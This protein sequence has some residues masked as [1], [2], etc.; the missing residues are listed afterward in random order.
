MAGAPKIL[1]P[2]VAGFVLLQ[3]FISGMGPRYQEITGNLPEFV[4]VQLQQFSLD[5]GATPVK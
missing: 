5:A 1:T 2:P 4:S 3:H